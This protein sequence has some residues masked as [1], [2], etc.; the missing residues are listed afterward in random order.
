MSRTIEP[1]PDHHAHMACC[2]DVLRGAFVE[3][4]CRHGVGWITY[5][6][7]PTPFTE[8]DLTRIRDDT[9]APSC[10]LLY[11]LTGRRK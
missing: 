7:L 1:I 11:H 5:A 6:P 4:R 8:D 2:T 9:T 3:G 10:S